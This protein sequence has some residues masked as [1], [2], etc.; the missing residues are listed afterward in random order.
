MLILKYQ[1]SNDILQCIGIFVQYGR[2]PDI[3]FAALVAGTSVSTVQVVKTMTDA[4][5]LPKG[6]PG[7]IGEKPCG[8]G[9]ETNIG[10]IGVL[11][12]FHAHRYGQYQMFTTYLFVYVWKKCM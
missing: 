12:G 3:V 9:I 8:D 4:P 5:G 2:S 11:M 1:I 7:K 10:I 6:K